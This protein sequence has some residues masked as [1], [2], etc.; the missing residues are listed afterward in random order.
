MSDISRRGVV[1][2]AAAN[3]LITNSKTAFGS[4]ANSSVSFGIIGTGGRGQLVG[5]LMS[6]VPQTRLTA[7]CDLYPDRIDAAK[8]KIPGADK[9]R[10]YK[11]YR[12]LLNQQ[13]IDAVLISTPVYLHPVHFEA[14]V[15]A[16]KHIYCEKP[17]GADVAGVKRLLKAA[18]RAEKNKSLQF[19]FQQRFAPQ[20]LKAR[21]VMRSGKIGDVKL[22]ISYW[23]LGGSPPKGFKNPYEGQSEE[24]TRNW[25]RWMEYSGGPIVEQDCHGLD[26]LNWFAEDVH[27]TRA[28]GT[29]G[30][31]YPIHY[32]DWRTDHHNITYFY[33]NGLEGYLIS[34]KHTADF[35]SVKEQLFGSLGLI[36]VARSYYRYHAPNANSPLRN[37]DD[38]Q[39]KTLMEEE[40]ARRDITAD[41]VQIFF[42]SIL[43]KKPINMVK[44]SA[45]STL[46][47]L[48]GRMA[49]DKRREVTWEELLKSA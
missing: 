4:Q 47:A 45:E 34:T 36:E 15:E 18:E 1:A 7:I 24:K 32:G 31:R 9:A 25:G 2:G 39:D 16:K 44:S 10:A 35:R 6:K 46:T 29:G 8:T 37:A 12:E 20:Y 3:L 17:A 33:P 13:D 26:I 22:M 28:V 49:I 30:L 48:L 43:E 11:D 5:T 41:A 27:P 14:A 38:L 42:N 21:D 40:E 23:V 19:G